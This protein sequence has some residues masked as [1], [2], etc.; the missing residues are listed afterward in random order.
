[1]VETA[2]TEEL[3]EHPLHPY[4]QGLMKAVPKLTG[5]GIALGIQGRIPD[6]MTPPGG[7]RFNPR[8]PHV[9]PIC[10]EQRPPFFM[11]KG[12]HEVACFLYRENPDG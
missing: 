8:C 2:R 4:T 3:F 11:T 7:C 12:R 6:Y 10:R 9:M 1:M 5:E